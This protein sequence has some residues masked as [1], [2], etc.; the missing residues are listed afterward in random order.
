MT[1]Y[2]EA[3]LIAIK[4]CFSGVQVYP[5]DFHCEQTWEQWTNKHKVKEFKECALPLLRS[6][7]NAPPFLTPHFQKTQIISKL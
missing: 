5:C 3:E 4:Q 1:D 6:Y 2:S 7:A